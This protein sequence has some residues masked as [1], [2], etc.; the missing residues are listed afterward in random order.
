MSHQATL[1]SLLFAGASA[2]LLAGCDVEPGSAM[3]YDLVAHVDLHRL[4]KASWV[5]KAMEGG[6]TEI[7]LHPDGKNTTETCTALL[8]EADALTMG[9]G[10]DRVEIYVEGKFDDAR[11]DK[12]FDELKAQFAGGKAKTESGKAQKVRTVELGDAL[13]GVAIG[14]DPLPVPSKA[15][16]QDLLDAEPSQSGN[17]ALWFTVQNG[18]KNENVKYAEGWANTDKGF[19]AHVQLELKDAATATELHAQAQAILFAL[20]VSS[21]TAD[22]VKGIKLKASGD[23]ITADVSATEKL[24]SKA[25][26][27]MKT[28]A[29][30]DGKGATIKIEA[31]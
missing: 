29:G 7:K 3:D 25:V 24:M 16:L 4:Q 2:A 27:S 8:E 11:T 31:K 18:P 5:K 9:T 20:K 10:N 12:C 21:D 14:P 17:E 15:R 30:S 13:V 1:R 23:T 26:T 22:L 28:E 6:S 19:A